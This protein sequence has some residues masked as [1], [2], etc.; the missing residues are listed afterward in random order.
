M[1]MGSS[2]FSS[3]I[4]SQL[5]RGRSHVRVSLLLAADLL[6]LCFSF[7][8][9][10]A[11]RL[12]T[13]TPL[14]EDLVRHWRILIFAIVI[15]LA[16]LYLTHAYRDLTRYATSQSLYRFAIRS[17]LM[18]AVVSQVS[19]LA[20]PQPYPSFWILYWASFVASG[21]TLRVM[22]RDILQKYSAQGAWPDINNSL[23]PALIYGAGESGFKLFDGL[24]N[25][26]QFHIVGYLDSD[27]SL[28]RRTLHG[29]PIHDPSELQFL[30]TTRHIKVILLALPHVSRLR[31]RELVKWLTQMHL[32]VL[33][34][35]SVSQLASGKV[36][37]KDVKTVAIEDL[38]GREP[39]S[40]I[41][42]LITACVQSMNVLVTGA[43][44]SI[45]SD[46]S[47]KLIELKA[48]KIVMLDH[49][50]EALYTV[51]LEL[52]LAISELESDCCRPT[53]LPILGNAC[54]TQLLESVIH[55]EGIDTIYHAAA[56]KHVPLLEGN[57]CSGI[58]NNM[59]ATR[60]IV[61]AA[62]KGKVRWLSLISSDKAVRPT[63]VMGASKRVCELIVQAAAADLAEGGPKLSIVRFGNVL[64][65]SGS[66]VPLFNR[67]IMKGGPITVTDPSVTRY[68]MTRQEAV[69]LVL[70]STA[71]STNG[72]DIFLLDMGEEVK[73]AELARQ[74]VELS[75]LSIRDGQ[76]PDGDIEIIFTG[77][78][79]GEKL[80]EEL[81]I[82]GEPEGTQHP[83]IWRV[84]EP[85]I[86]LQQL[87]PILDNMEI[88]TAARDSKRTLELLNVLVPE[89][90]SESKLS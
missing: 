12:N 38:L 49:S 33:S 21:V 82:S 73:I 52:R 10:F 44:G 35:P 69:D 61:N 34:I 7:I 70:Q 13:S 53:I 71:L 6:L 11:L 40:P 79:A 60:S 85:F 26:P 9:S 77:L 31:K 90:V 36:Q 57:I 28:Q 84:E 8:I 1:I 83:L 4:L 72:G 89:F 63:N 43:G 27:N 15:G 56:Y 19:R 67:L 81:F 25:D 75:G 88:A 45:G 22:F 48:N 46:I 17:T 20:G 68:F 14:G 41:E 2:V 5:M 74:M 32:K 66:V 87:N 23:T 51:D 65:T 30:I 64:E 47:K 39:T 76:N 55:N 18:V 80:Y 16:I 3:L 54:D 78:R 37:L 29:L 50:E 86:H 58:A 59:R 62:I 24:R 42:T